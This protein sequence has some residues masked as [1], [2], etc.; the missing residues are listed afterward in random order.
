MIEINSEDQYAIVSGDTT[1][2]EL[3]T[4]LPLGLQYR[5][6]RLPL[7]LEDWLLSGGL[8]LLEMPP[9]RKD[10]LGLTYTAAHGTVSVGGKV[11]KNVAG[12]DAVRLVIGSDASLTRRVRIESAILR[13]RPR[14]PV[15]RLEQIRSENA[16]FSVLRELGAAYA[17]AY[18]QDST[19]MLRAEFWGSQPNWGQVISSDLSPN[20]EFHDALGVFPRA[21][22]ELSA[23]EARVLNAL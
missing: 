16:I 19:W 6:P 20:L 18:K 22:K 21:K 23:L 12:Y 1:L 11:V 5:A 2:Q 17:V 9:I 8:G 14:V 10:V 4:A 7:T 3:E 13:L 15:V